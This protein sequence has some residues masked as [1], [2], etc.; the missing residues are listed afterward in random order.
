M[1]YIDLFVIPVLQAREDDYRKS[2]ELGRTVWMEHGALTYLECRADDVP[3]GK[4]TSLPMAVKLEP[5]EIIYMGFATY[6]DR[7][8]RDAV[9]ALVFADPRLEDMMKDSPAAMQR[10]IWGGFEG[11]VTS[12]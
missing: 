7:A 8:H 5:G 1:A 6:R 11:V 4:L 9:K 10:M 12:G 3:D 2:A